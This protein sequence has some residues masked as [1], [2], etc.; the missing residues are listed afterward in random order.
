MAGHSKWSKVKRM[1]GALDSKRGMLF[2][3]LSKEIT[4]AA[5]MGGGNPSLNHR[6]RAAVQS[7]RSQ[8]MPNDNIERAIKKGTGELG[9]AA[10]EEMVYEGYAAGG[11]AVL[12]EAATDNKNRMAA[13]MRQIF[14]KNHGSLGV[15]GSVSY[16]FHRVGQ[17]TVPLALA[18][19]DRIL[20]IILDAGAEEIESDDS[21]HN[22][23]T[24]PDKLYAVSDALRAAGIEPD[25]Q[26][27][28]F[29]PGTTV[30]ITEESI[31]DQVLKLCDSLEDNDDVLNVHSNF[32]ISEDL[33][34]AVHGG[35]N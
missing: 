26:K 24:P 5:R 15:P 3:R 2:S 14:S 19:E 4:I 7:A 18:T 32:D 1:K 23:T 21:H 6:L 22:I 9:A 29:I 35:H 17:I 27:L 10:V 20:E 31:A 28:T 16:L 30:G 25:S 13:D 8:S 11:I 34:A 12:V 33:L